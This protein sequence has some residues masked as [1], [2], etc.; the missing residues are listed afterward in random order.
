MI[1]KDLFFSCT[2]EIGIHIDEETFQKFDRYAVLLR[3][4]NEKVN[5]TAITDADG[6]TVKHFADSLFLLKYV[7][8]GNGAKVCD[9]GTGAGF[10]G[11]ALLL[12]RPDLN[13][14][15]FDSVNKKLEFIRFLCRE[16]DVQAEIVNI[17][18]ED[19]GKSPLYREKYDLATARAVASLNK[20]SEY[21][22]PLIK[23]GGQF[24]PLKAVLSDEEKK[25]GIK[26]AEKLG[27]TLKDDKLYE[28]RKGEGREILIFE[29]ISHTSP[30]YPRNPALVSK[31]PLK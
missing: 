10:P 3:E 27:C 22:V 28:I 9:V 24:T 21:C 7:K 19:A 4:Y 15:L 29:K 16:L 1:S 8:P 23:I 13:V 25:D 12:A 14:T 11:M 6:I 2:E 5:L 26:A 17:R 30:K 18:A 31:N 20:L